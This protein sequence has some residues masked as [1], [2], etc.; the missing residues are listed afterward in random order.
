MS[1]GCLCPEWH[2]SGRA[3]TSS[4][5]LSHSKLAHPWDHRWNAFSHEWK[6]Q[7]GSSDEKEGITQIV[8][9]WAHTSWEPP[10][11]VEPKNEH[12]LPEGEK[13]PGFLLRSELLFPPSPASQEH[14]HWLLLFH[15]HFN[16]NYNHH[17]SCN[18]GSSHYQSLESL[19]GEFIKSDTQSST[20]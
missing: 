15:P 1:A 4:P 5:V 16:C 7:R 13:R 19:I 6:H 8:V 10:Y 3:V 12:Q 11:F 20:V 14:R 18:C 2:R 9:S 17:R